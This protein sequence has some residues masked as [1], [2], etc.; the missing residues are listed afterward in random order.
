MSTILHLSFASSS[1]L[2]SLLNGGSRPSSRLSISRPTLASLHRNSFKLKPYGE[3]LSFFEVERVQ[4][5]ILVKEEKLKRNTRVVVVRFNRGFGF[6]GGG[7]GGGRDNGATARV[8]GNLVLAIGLTYLSMTG[9]LG[10]VLDAIVSIWLLVVLIPIVGL[11]AFLWWAG[12]DIVQSSSLSLSVWLLKWISFD[13]VAFAVS[14]LWERF[15]DFQIYF[16]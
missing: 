1:T 7:G 10:W 12:R 3:K 16:E 9:Q 5:G 2:R 13:I 4:N 6:N 14:K 15:S 11:G 8:V